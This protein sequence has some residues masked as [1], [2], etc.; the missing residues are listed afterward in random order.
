MPILHNPTS[1]QVLVPSSPPLHKMILL[2]TNSDLTPVECP[3]NVRLYAPLRLQYIAV[4]SLDPVNTPFPLRT[5]QFLIYK[6]MQLTKTTLSNSHYSWAPLDLYSGSGTIRQ[7]TSHKGGWKPEI[8]I[9]YTPE[10]CPL[11]CKFSS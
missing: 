9:T 6:F 2:M 1:A 10:T 8:F 5:I 4:Q 3:S 11:V 7:S